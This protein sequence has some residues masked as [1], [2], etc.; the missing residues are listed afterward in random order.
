MKPQAYVWLGRMA[1]KLQKQ[2]EESAKA[3]LSGIMGGAVV[4]G[5]LE[6]NPIYREIAAVAFAWFFLFAGYILFAYLARDDEEIEV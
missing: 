3:L 4:A 1:I 6:P 5:V 2:L